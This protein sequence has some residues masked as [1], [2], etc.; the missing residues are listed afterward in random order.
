VLSVPESIAKLALDFG[1][2]SHAPSGGRTKSLSAVSTGGGFFC[3]ARERYSHQLR[4]LAG[5]QAE[6]LNRSLGPAK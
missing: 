6:L 3:A 2:D 5:G 1:V 4:H